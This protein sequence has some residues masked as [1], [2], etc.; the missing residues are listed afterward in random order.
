M[1]LRFL[2]TEAVG[3]TVKIL[4]THPCERSDE[5]PDNKNTHTLLLAG[6]FR[7]GHDILVCS[8]LLLLDTVT[9]QVT[10]RSS[11]ELPVDII[12][13]PVG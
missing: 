8:Q 5:V 1:I 3:N 2:W 7:A 6:V 4:G 10:A 11:E 13:A 9:M 12:V